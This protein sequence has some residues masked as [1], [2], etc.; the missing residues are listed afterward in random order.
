MASFVK[1]WGEG[2][3]TY[4]ATIKTDR[5]T[6]TDPSSIELHGQ[7]LELWTT[8]PAGF[9]AIVMAE[10]IVSCIL[11]T[12]TICLAT[13]SK[14]RTVRNNAGT[15]SL[16]GGASADR[17]GGQQNF[18]GPPDVS[19]DFVAGTSGFGLEVNTEGTGLTDIYAT[20]SITIT[21]HQISTGA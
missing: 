14:I 6:I 4:F 9:T 17:T 16:I 7:E 10:I 1:E 20:A 11:S 19:V 21:A 13:F 3:T 5:T 8:I 18:A 12:S 2:G 15:I